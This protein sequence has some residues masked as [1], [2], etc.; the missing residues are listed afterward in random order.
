MR[1]GPNL[2]PRMATVWETLDGPSVF[3]FC[4]QVFSFLGGDKIDIRKE[5]WPWGR[6]GEGGVNVAVWSSGN[7]RI[8]ASLYENRK[9]NT[10]QN[11]HE[12]SD[13]NHVPHPLKKLFCYRYS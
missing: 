13:G 5:R 3:H 10:Q 7:K 2:S 1:A 11:K 9:T 8:T 12:N 6:G 4:F